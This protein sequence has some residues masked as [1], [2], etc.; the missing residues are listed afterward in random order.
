MKIGNGVDAWNDLP[1]LLTDTDHPAFDLTEEDVENIKD[2]LFAD[3]EKIY[4]DKVLL[5]VDWGGRLTQADANK[6]IDERLNALE[7]GAGLPE[8][9]DGGSYSRRIL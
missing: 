8:V 3:V 6:Y 2:L 1:Y 5:R 9:I 4:T 7:A